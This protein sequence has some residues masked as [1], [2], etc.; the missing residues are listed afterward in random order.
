MLD[1]S[2]SHDGLTAIGKKSSFVV[3]PLEHGVSGFK[4]DVTH[5]AGIAIC[6]LGWARYVYQKE[7]AKFARL[8]RT[9]FHINGEE[10]AKTA[11]MGIE[12]MKDFYLSIGMP[13]SL[14]EVGINEIDL[15]KIA[16]L[17][18]GNGTHVIGCCPQSL[19]KQDIEAVYRLCL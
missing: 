14:K 4:A 10:D 2:L 3:H 17:V 1:S 18:S 16:N 19:D 9:L 7:P 11:I 6:Y 8:A 13:T 5:G 15:P 12:A